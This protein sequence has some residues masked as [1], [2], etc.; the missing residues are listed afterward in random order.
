MKARTGVVQPPIIKEYSSFRARSN[1]LIICHKMN[2]FYTLSHTHTLQGLP[3]REL[4]SM[5]KN[6][7]HKKLHFLHRDNCCSCWAT[8]NK[9]ALNTDR[10]PG[11]RS[12]GPALL[13]WRVPVGVARAESAERGAAPCPQSCALG[14]TP[15]YFWQDE[16]GGGGAG[17]AAWRPGG[18]CAAERRAVR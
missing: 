2:V 12:D 3:S 11:G 6:D 5:L 4:K 14:A 16:A 13:L 18:R 7:F 15:E 1:I 8:A 10:M 9:P 17:P